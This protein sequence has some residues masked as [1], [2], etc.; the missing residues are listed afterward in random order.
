[1]F[2]FVLLAL[3][4]PVSAKL[5]N[6]PDTQWHIAVGRWIW[7]HGWVPETDVFS[8]TFAGA[9][10]IAKEWLSQLLLFA[11]FASAGWWG[12]A[13]MTAVVIAASFALLYFWLLR[14]LRPM[15]AFT[16]MLLALMLAGPQFLARPH[17]LVVPV[18]LLWTLGLVS[19][20]ERRKTPP[21]WL[22]CLMAFWA[23]MHASFPLGL[24]VA[25]LLAGEAVFSASPG[26]RR[27][28]L[29][30]WGLFLLVSTAAAGVSPYGFKTVLVILGLFQSAEAM[31]YID[32]WQPL[33]FDPQGIAAV[34]ALA[35]SLAI[36]VARWRANLF[37]IAA[38]VLLGYL[39]V[40]HA[41]FVLLFAVVAPVLAAGPAALRFEG[42]RTA[43][44][45]AKCAVPW[46]LVAP[47]AM[48]TLAVAVFIRPQPNPLVTP[49]A[50]FSSAQA[51]GVTGA[52]YND[53]DFGGFLILQGVKTFVDGRTDQLF[54]DGFITRLNRAIDEKPSM[55]FA[56]LLAERKVGWAIV[57]TQSKDARHLAE[58]GWPKI[59][60][61]KVA[62]VYV[63]SC[64]EV[65]CR[66]P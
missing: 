41:R 66:Q 43:G 53:F 46:R 21:L 5:L 45:P 24:V 25:G 63:K 60:E 37:R 61:D 42:V 9:P 29:L 48:V 55:D 36:L 57:R 39:M 7:A 17:I 50:A 59:F 13:M 32:E 6:D 64:A 1:M 12:V 31:R 34:A 23:N 16:A 10:W 51:H 56:D 18:M 27:A 49:A 40:R 28:S 54:L 30:G 52:V 20:V 3:L 26:Q 14:F 62:A 47:L 58:M 15:L 38:T 11:A 4:L 2:F 8:H 19:A 35:L 22:A 33:A 44:M 65:D